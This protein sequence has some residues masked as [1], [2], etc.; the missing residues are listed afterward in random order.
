MLVTSGPLPPDDERYGF[1]VKWD[2]F[3]ALI[4]LDAGRVAITSR[5]GY[6]MTAHYPELVVLAEGCHRRALLD[7]EIVCLDA[8][9]RPDFAGLWF[10]SRGRPAG[11]VCFMAFDIL[12]ADDRA[13]LDRPLSERRVV[14][15]SL[16]LEGSGCHISPAYIGQ[17]Q[18]LLAATRELGLEGVVAKRMCSSYRPGMRSRSWIKTKHMRTQPFGVVGWLPATERRHRDRGGVVIS[19]LSEG[20]FAGYAGIIESGSSSDLVDR[21]PHLT[22]HEVENFARGLNALPAEI[23]ADVRFLEF[24]AAGGL[25]HA[26]IVGIDG[27]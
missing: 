15:E 18:A 11:S 22:R 9:G 10:R 23:I 14:L 7:G 2:G 6:D 5:K 19:F 12:E 17:G 16:G 25:R 1:E 21:L 3:R 8:D 13:L 24:S 26:S 27:D 4:S 20:E